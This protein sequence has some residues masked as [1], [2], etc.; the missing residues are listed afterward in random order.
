M[1]QPLWPERAR[2][3]GADRPRH[4][5]R[6]R[7]DLDRRADARAA[8]PPPR[9]EAGST[10][11]RTR[12][13]GPRSTRSRTP[14]CGRHAAGSARGWSRSSR[15]RSV[16]DR[17]LRGDPR[18]YVEAAARAFDPDVLTIGFARRVATYKR[19]DLLTRDPEWTLSLLGGERPV[20]V[21]LAG[22]AHPRDEE[23]KRE[24]QSAVRAQG[25]R[26][27]VGERV[28]FLD[29]YDLTSAHC[30]CRAATCG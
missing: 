21:V 28:V 29:D 27:I 5:R 2:R 15:A 30:S 7:A 8:R 19:L 26:R 22:K 9:P 20:Q 24:L 1:W 25:A 6:A 3:R 4:Q 17:L 13:C 14:S 10:A 12:G 18:E 23:A 16:A 11:P